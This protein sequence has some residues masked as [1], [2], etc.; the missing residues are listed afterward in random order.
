MSMSARRAIKR[1]NTSTSYN[2][3]TSNQKYNA[4]RKYVVNTTNKRNLNTQLPSDFDWREY[5]ALNPDLS[6]L[7]ETQAI[8]HYLLYGINEKR[9]YKIE[10]IKSLDIKY[11]LLNENIQSIYINNPLWCH[12]H[13]NNPEDII[14]NE[15]FIKL[16]KY[17]S[18]IFT[19][20]YNI[21]LNTSSEYT[22][23]HIDCKHPHIDRK[24]YV[25][26]YL[27]DNNYYNDLVISV[28]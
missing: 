16:S 14:N 18:I 8:K 21:N 10:H 5:V 3:T 15:D 24:T 6:H 25:L 7:N 19:C 2:R 13:S 27:N 28:N 20:D 1:R 17:F 4:Y 11:R 9:Q 22:Y 12:I 26:K 23:L